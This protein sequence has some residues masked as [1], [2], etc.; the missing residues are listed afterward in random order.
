MLVAVNLPREGGIFEV[1]G[2][3]AVHLEE[4]A[5]PCTGPPIAGRSGRV[6]LEKED[7]SGGPVRIERGS[8]W[9]TSVEEE[10]LL[11]SRGLYTRRLVEKSRR[12]WR[13]FAESRRLE[14]QKEVFRWPEQSGCRSGAINGH[15]RSSS[16]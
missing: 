5:A 1:N 10:V 11:A 12:S 9:R 14:G 7:T 16:Y 4:C 6:E 13:L 15:F 8:R 2:S 3:L